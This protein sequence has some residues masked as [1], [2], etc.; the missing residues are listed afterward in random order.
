MA[1][2]RK[3]YTNINKENKLNLVFD[4]DGVVIN[5]INVQQC[6]FYGSY[7]EIVGDD[8]CPP[9]SEYMKYTGDS[10]PNIF[11]KMGL[12]VKMAEPYRRISRKAIDQIIINEELVEMIR[13]FRQYGVKCGICTGKD[14]DRTVEILR[15]F[16]IEE[17]FD[18]VV[19]SDDVSEPK[20]SA[21]PLLKAIEQMG[22]DVNISNSI[23]IGDGY[24][25]ILSAK[26]AGCRV[27]LTLWYG[28]EGVPR[29]SDY[30]VETVQEL[31][32]LLLEIMG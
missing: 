11:T 8:K 24:Y 26:N 2:E 15:F 4:F 13:E 19:A 20:P 5:S 23:V 31:R 12:P 9:F 16:G 30:V 29:E 3:I 18:S 32:R 1:I 28:D 14:H 10:L 7:K 21:M 6:A 17:L 25:D 22:D 27:V